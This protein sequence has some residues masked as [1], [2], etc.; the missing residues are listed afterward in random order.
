MYVHH[1]LILSEGAKI[2]TGILM[3]CNS[4]SGHMTKGLSSLVV[5][6]LLQNIIR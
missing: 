5:R 2:I 1:F 6:S 3:C 4:Y